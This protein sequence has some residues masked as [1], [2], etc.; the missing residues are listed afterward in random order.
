MEAPNCY[1]CKHRG[2]VPGDAHSCCNYPGT[3]TGM[4]DIFSN[5]DMI[6]KL[7]I[8]GDDHG[9]RNGW[10]MWPVNFDPSWL[11]SC[12][13]FFHKDLQDL[14]LTEAKPLKWP[15]FV[16]KLPKHIKE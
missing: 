9:I 3:K 11:I 5:G 7:G 1:K 10:F 4:F 12:N 16:M 14:E 2:S 13:G 6:T 15:R 8:R